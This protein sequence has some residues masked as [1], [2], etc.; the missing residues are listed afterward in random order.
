MINSDKFSAGKMRTLLIGLGIVACLGGVAYSFFTIQK[1]SGEEGQYAA[2]AE[3]L[4]SLARQVAVSSQATR[5]GQEQDFNQLAE[6]VKQFEAQLTA[7][8]APELNDEIS[9]VDLNWQPIKR[10]AQTL[11]DAAPRAIFV[12]GVAAELEKNIK[13]MQRELS[14]VVTVLQRQRVSTD[15]LIAAQKAPWLLERMARNVDR[16]LVGDSDS[17]LAADEF[18]SDAADFFRIIEGLTRGDEL[19]GINKVTSTSAIEA[20]SNAFR[21]FSGVSTSV[22]R[23]AGASTELRQA[24]LARQTIVENS[25]PLNDAI[26]TLQPAIASLAVG[27][28]YD[29]GNLLILFI[30]PGLLALGLL[31]TMMLGQRRRDAYTA[32]GVA[33]VNGVLEQLSKGDL[34]VSAAE[35]NSVTSDIAQ[36]LNKATQRQCQ[37]IRD[38]RQPFEAAVDEI[39]RIGNSAQAQVEKGRE[40]TR[41]VVESTET[42]T[43]MVRTSEEI[44]Q[45][46]AEAADTSDRNCKTVTQGYEL[47]KDMSKASADVR[48]SVQETSKTAK[49]QGEL[50]QSVTAAAEYIQ[51]LN[52]KIS[53]VAINTRIEAEKAGEY[54]RPFLGIAESIAD[55]LREAEEEGRKII[56]EV[57]MLQNMSADNLASMEN[58]VGTVVTIL[59]Y[60]DRLDSSLEEINAGSDAISEIIRNVDEAAGQSAVNAL[61]M[62]SSMAEIRERNL[63]IS[64]LNETAQKGV[65]SLQRSMRDAAQ[66]L[67]QFRIEGDSAY[68]AAVATE[69]DVSDLES[70]RAAT[71]VYREEEMSALE[72]AEKTRASL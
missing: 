44:K 11:V 35:D 61:H 42:A 17:Q 52:T 39:D 49:R 40:L 57:R 4:S 21:L 33:D 22:D 9:M 72:S 37:L 68:Q 50:I 12:Q 66:N 10:A 23:I 24:A 36:G 62:S 26:A 65:N 19:I 18:S 64:E 54:G 51:A 14:S 71:Q 53:V 34:T 43:E 41:S 27:R 58:T 31:V 32:R 60:I 63:E 30:A 16:T 48:E 55:L 7:I 6:Q 5:N 28:L 45:S 69:G 2:A 67:G 38:I 46:T 56:S 8:D 25:V 20:L 70:I 13:P 1:E 29:A 47:T 15:T 59:E 3:S